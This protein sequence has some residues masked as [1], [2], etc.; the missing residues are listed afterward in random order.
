MKKLKYI[1]FAFISIIFFVSCQNETKNYLVKKWDCVQIENLAPVDKNFASKEDS[2]VA[3]KVETA[4]KSL[5]W[6]FNK[7][8]TYQCSIGDRITTQ[9]TYEISADEKQ[10][11]CTSVTKNSINTYLIT[12]ISD[13]EMTLTGTGT[14]VPLILHFRPN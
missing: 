3:E 1:L 4:L 13:I 12:S 2:V 14:S 7:N 10:L 5:N 11:T 9:G 6:S 8:N